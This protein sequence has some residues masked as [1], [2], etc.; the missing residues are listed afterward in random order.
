M[1]WQLSLF[2]S[3]T[4][5][6]VNWFRFTT[7]FNRSRELSISFSSSPKIINHEVNSVMGS[8]SCL[9]EAYSVFLTSITLFIWFKNICPN[10][11]LWH[12]RILEKMTIAF[13]IF[14]VL[15]LAYTLLF[16]KPYSSL[17]ILLGFSNIVI[18]MCY[19]LRPSSWFRIACSFDALCSRVSFLSSCFRS[20]LN[21]SVI[22]LNYWSWIIFLMFSWYVASC[23]NFPRT[24]FAS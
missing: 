14:S 4:P 8:R 13:H 11:Y 7:P 18:I 3:P 5:Q 20:S 16:L 9:F 1:P 22:L 17:A 24:L 21:P 12:P 10:S 15:I 2:A 6:A 23:L 19:S